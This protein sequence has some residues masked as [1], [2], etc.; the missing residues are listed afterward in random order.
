MR[1]Q[2]FQSNQCNNDHT[3]EPNAYDPAPAYYHSQIALSC[4]FSDVWCSYAPQALD[5]D[6]AHLMTTVIKLGL[7]RLSR[8]RGPERK[9][10]HAPFG[11]KALV[12]PPRMPPL[13]EAIRRQDD[14]PPAREPERVSTGLLT[15]AHE[16]AD[17]S[18]ARPEPLGTGHRRVPFRAAL[19]K[20]ARIAHRLENGRHFRSHT[21]C[22]PETRLH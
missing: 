14:P 7:R 13:A 6:V 3:Y 8:H 16:R 15:W 9:K 18:T 20:L 11:A 22:A 5:N 4:A 2:S 10:E 1:T 12:L 17:P 19:D 21:I